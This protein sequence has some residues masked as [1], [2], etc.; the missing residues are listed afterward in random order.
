MK[1]NTQF[2]HIITNR[3]VIVDRGSGWFQIGSGDAG[4]RGKRSMATRV[5][6]PRKKVVKIWNDQP[7]VSRRQRPGR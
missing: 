1:A 5:E 4:G 2:Y 7:Q 6:T 3:I